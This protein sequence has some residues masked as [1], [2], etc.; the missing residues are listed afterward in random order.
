[1]RFREQKPGD[2]DRAR[3]AA[4]AWR[5]NHPAGTCDDLIAAVG[6][7]FHPDWAVVLRSVLFAVDRHRARRITGVVT[8]STGP[9]R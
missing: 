2:L 4:A 6:P 3:A 5:E 9:S 7:A 8:G 1:M